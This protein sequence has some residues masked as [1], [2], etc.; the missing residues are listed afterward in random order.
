MNN[1]DW[2]EWMKQPLIW[3][4][5]MRSR[6]LVW[7]PDAHWFINDPLGPLPHSHDDASEIIYIAAGHMDIQVGETKQR[8]GPGELLFMPP[9]RY[10]NYWLVGDETVCL[11]VLV[12]PN[13][14]QSRWRYKDF[15]PGAFE[16]HAPMKSAFADDS[17][18]K[19]PSD[20]RISTNV[21][22]LDV[23]ADTGD[24]YETIKEKMIY[25]LEGECRIEVEKLSGTFNHNDYQH[26]PNQHHHRII[27]TGTGPL[28]YFEFI[29]F[30]PTAPAIIKPEDLHMVKEEK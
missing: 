5:R 8:V 29:C 10:H 14:K 4:E 28:R 24:L 30:D 26:V 3:T 22:V 18:Q 21:R 19:M 16:G 1:P 7:T 6:A 25:V 12:V 9:D 11:Y 15:K 23:G 13:N 27:N 20:A 17:V 2:K